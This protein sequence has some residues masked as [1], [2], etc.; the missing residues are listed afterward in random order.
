MV[1]TNPN[2]SDPFAQQDRRAGECLGRISVMFRE[3]TDPALR[4]DDR[5]QLMAKIAREAGAFHAWAKAE[6][7]RL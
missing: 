5:K 6:S 2:P 3:A 7:D 4:L 1:P